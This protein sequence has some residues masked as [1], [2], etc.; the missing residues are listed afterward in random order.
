LSNLW[1]LLATDQLDGADFLAAIRGVAADTDA[2]VMSALLDQLGNINQT[3]IVPDLRDEFAT[4]VQALLSPTLDR[5]GTEPVAGEDPATTTLRPQILL[6]LA[7]YGRDEIARAVVAE[8]T[9]RYLAG[10]IAAS[11]QVD[12]AMRAMARLGDARLFDQYRDGFA[13][14][15]SPNDR[16]RY[17]QALGSFRDPD[18]VA[19]V[20]DYAMSGPLQTIEL[21]EVLRRLTAWD[22]NRA[23]LLRWLMEN[24][25]QLRERLPESTMARIPDSL[26]RCSTEHLQTIIDFYGATE[27]SVAGIESELEDSEAEVLECAAFRARELESV[28][29]YL[30]DGA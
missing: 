26:T 9:R 1:A 7:D 12:V 25:A 5:I 17:I 23:I 10:E 22:D 16:L 18:V 19:D 8:Q 3:F 4:F 27:R 2:A 15:T 6:W 14:A 28:R 20:L 21:T 30:S 29:Q 13:A 11:D 24:D